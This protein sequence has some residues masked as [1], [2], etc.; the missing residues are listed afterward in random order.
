MG[1]SVKIKYSHPFGRFLTKTLGQRVL[2]LILFIFMTLQ[3]LGMRFCNRR[4][5]N[6][7]NMVDAK[8]FNNFITCMCQFVDFKYGKWRYH[9]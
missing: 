3:L 6:I 4:A 8:K 7:E 1:F 5:Y 9:F 2:Q